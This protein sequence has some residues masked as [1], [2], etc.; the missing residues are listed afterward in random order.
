MSETLH[1]VGIGIRWVTVYC[2]ISISYCWGNNCSIVV[3]VV[4][5]VIVI[6]IIGN[7]VN[8]NALLLYYPCDGG[9]DAKAEQ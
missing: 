3:A 6:I 1:I 5:V 9:E 2:R 4:I 8:N 7:N